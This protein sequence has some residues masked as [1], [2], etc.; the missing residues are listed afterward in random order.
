ML[1]INACLF[2]GDFFYLGEPGVEYETYQAA[3][4]IE[5]ISFPTHAFL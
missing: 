5:L 4:D 1:N 2:V 3:S